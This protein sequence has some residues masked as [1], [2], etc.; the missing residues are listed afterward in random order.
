MLAVHGVVPVGLRGRA[1][2]WMGESSDDGAAAG[3]SVPAGGGQVR[4]RLVE[5]GETA[6]AVTDA[7]ALPQGGEAR[8]HE[9]V[10]ER[11]LE[12]RSVVPAPHGFRARDEAAVRGFLERARLPLREAL[13]Y[14][15][16]CWELRL[17]MLAPGS[18]TEEGPEA[19]GP[20]PAGSAAGGTGP[21]KEAAA[22]SRQIFRAL[23]HRARTARRLPASGGAVFVG[24]FLLPRGEWVAF[25]EEVA[26]RES[27]SPGVELDVTGPW[28]PYDFVRM[29]PAGPATG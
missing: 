17:R 8:V 4:F 2:G 23:R 9:R 3:G 26:R 15:E 5:V 24:A 29:M 12:S 19:G 16:G 6:A 11:L 1:R 28:A 13:E 18:R 25:V 22:L 20:G 10:V 7:S 14:L 21:P 27:R